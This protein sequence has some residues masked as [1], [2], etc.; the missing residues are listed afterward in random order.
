MV[1]APDEVCESAVSVHLERARETF[2]AD[3][4][5]GVVVSAE[6]ALDGNPTDE[7]AAEALR[8]LA[9]AW[10]AE[11][12]LADAIAA[13]E[14][15]LKLDPW[16]RSGP[17]DALDLRARLVRWQMRRAIAAVRAG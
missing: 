5:L 11:D 12:L 10:A 6:D 4:F 14:E 3:D 15:A 1:V 7:E 13:A 2:A 9:V 16:A 17:V 8:M